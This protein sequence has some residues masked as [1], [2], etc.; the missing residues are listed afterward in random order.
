MRV[1]RIQYA[2][3]A[4]KVHLLHFTDGYPDEWRTDRAPL[5]EAWERYE[6]LFTDSA[7]NFSKAVEPFVAECDWPLG[8]VY[9]GAFQA[10]DA[11]AY[12]AMIRGLRPSRI[13]EVGGGNSTKFAL[14]ALAMNGAGELMCID[15]SP[16]RALPDGVQHLASRIEDVPLETFER[17]G[18]GDILFIDS[19]HTTAEARH[20]VDTLLPSLAPGVVVQHHDI[21]YPFAIAWDDPGAMAEQDLLLDFY[22]GHD[23][24]EVL[25]GNAYLT[26]RHADVVRRTVPSY[27]WVP[28]MIAG[29]LWT[30]RRT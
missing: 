24:F 15:P 8:R 2:K 1:D 22:D 28:V 13:I 21:V 10:V 27:R 18:D 7:E 4:A 30:R 11:E 17:L 5:M 19:S 25:F 26:F 12:H 16:H 20:H 3:R 23:E 9:N 6:H 29:S 14:E